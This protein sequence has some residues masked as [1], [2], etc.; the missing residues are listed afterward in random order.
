MNELIFSSESVLEITKVEYDD[1]ER[2]MTLQGIRFDE[3]NKE[4]YEK[5]YN[6]GSYTYIHLYT[7]ENGIIHVAPLKV[8]ESFKRGGIQRSD[9]NTS[10]PKSTYSKYTGQLYKR[11]GSENTS[12][13]IFPEIQW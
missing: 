1:F 12:L 11:R 2:F 7:P 8:W 9:F 3:K 10:E 13:K 5:S 4:W 6:L